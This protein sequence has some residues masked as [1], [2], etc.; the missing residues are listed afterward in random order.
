[1]IKQDGSIAMEMETDLKSMLAAYARSTRLALAH[2][3]CVMLALNEKLLTEDAI[4][5][6]CQVFSAVL[7]EEK[8][9]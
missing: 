6:A 2:S 9:N 3:A 8:N 5:D 1:M 7:Q 4:G